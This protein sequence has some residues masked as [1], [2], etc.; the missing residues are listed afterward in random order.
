MPSRT[1]I[2]LVRCS[3][4]REGFNW[5]RDIPAFAA[6]C[7]IPIPLLEEVFAVMIS[8]RSIASSLQ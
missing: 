2:F 3:S 6:N 5:L 4:I 1:I 8:R 7:T